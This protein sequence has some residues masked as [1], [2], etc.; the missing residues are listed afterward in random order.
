MKERDI[1]LTIEGLGTFAGTLVYS[2]NLNPC[3]CEVHRSANDLCTEQ[4]NV[5]RS[6]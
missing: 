2:R 6:I 4:D 3:Y 5:N 1:V